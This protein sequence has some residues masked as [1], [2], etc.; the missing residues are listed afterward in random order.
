[1]TLECAD[2]DDSNGWKN[3]ILGKFVKNALFV[4]YDVT[5]FYWAISC[6][7]ADRFL[8]TITFYGKRWLQLMNQESLCPEY[9]SSTQKAD[10][11]VGP[12]QHKRKKTHVFQYKTRFTLHFPQIDSFSHHN[13]STLLSR[14]CGYYFID[15]FR[16]NSLKD[17]KT[18]V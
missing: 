5:I 18:S 2:P 16:V 11:L 10:L 3:R 9:T 14:R 7:L 6:A 15:I 4:V 17:S 13:L 8:I 1:M 12:H